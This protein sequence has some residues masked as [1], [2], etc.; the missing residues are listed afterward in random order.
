MAL[1]HCVTVDVWHFEFN[2][3]KVADYIFLFF[4]NTRISC[5]FSILTKL[6]KDSLYLYDLSVLLLCL[7]LQS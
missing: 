3:I 5:T 4:F 1:K 2:G 7:T 6:N